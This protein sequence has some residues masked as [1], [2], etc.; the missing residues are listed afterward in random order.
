V[1]KKDHGVDIPHITV[2]EP[3]WVQQAD[4]LYLPNDNGYKYCLVVVDAANRMTDAEPLKEKTANAVLDA[5][6]KIY[7]RKI[8][9]M[10]HRLDVDSGAE[11][12]G[13]VKKYF[14]SNGV[15]MRVA[16]PGRHR[17]Q[18]MVERRNQ[19]IGTALFKR[20]QAQEL[21]TGETSTEWIEDLPKLIKALN[22]VQGKKNKKKKEKEPNV[23]VC[24]KDSC[25]LIPIGTKVRVA[26]D[27]PREQVHGQK[28]H[29][30]FRSTDVRWDVTERTVEQIRLRP[31]FP[32]MYNI[33]GI[34]DAAYTK[35]QL[36]VIDDDEQYPD[37]TVI[38]GKPTTYRVQKIL[39]SKKEKGR[40][41]LLIKYFGYPD[42]EW[43]PESIIKQD[44]PDIVKKWKAEQKKKTNQ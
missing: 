13:A 4:I 6:K 11:F 39:D 12:K 24:S 32:P 44:I 7:S 22:K 2:F 29:G 16:K 10:P 8:L 28:L 21:L 31:G 38:R 35:N 18:A 34:P 14:K 1:P 27:E 19:I 30:K 23:P 20:M 5:F 3:N 40:N 15:G 26:L 9:K 36:Q 17:Q 41:Y 37:H 33:S 42:P 25:K 43:Q